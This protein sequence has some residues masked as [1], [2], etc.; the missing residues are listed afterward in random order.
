[1]LMADSI[2]STKVC[3][4]CQ[5]AKPTDQFISK[6]SRS[7]SGGSLTVNC[8]G[9]RKR[10]APDTS[11]RTAEQAGLSPIRRQGLPLLDLQLGTPIISQEPIAASTGGAGVQVPIPS[12]PGPSTASQDGVRLGT[13]IESPVSSPSIW[14]RPARGRYSRPPVQ[15]SAMDRPVMERRD[16]EHPDPDWMSDLS[17]C[18]LSDRDNELLKKFWTELENDRMEH[19]TRCQETWFDMGLKNG[20]CK[21]CIAKDKNKKEDEPWFFSWKRC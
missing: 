15:Q 21:R 11:K 19:C 10:H 13:P 18:P 17:H 12:R 7:I 14:P 6:K 9:C 8:L 2:P 1:M 20:V 16:F 3:R 4:N 5:Q